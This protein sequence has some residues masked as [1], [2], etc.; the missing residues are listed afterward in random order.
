ME[1]R[2]REKK[3]NNFGADV[4]D[5]VR[6]WS[7]KT[8]SLLR[9]QLQSASFPETGTE[10]A[11]AAAADAAAKI[12]ICLSLILSPV[13]NAENTGSESDVPMA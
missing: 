9:Q 6:D 7:K 10:L 3:K 2:E 4:T 8:A 5:G 13:V 12:L 1:Q 11:A